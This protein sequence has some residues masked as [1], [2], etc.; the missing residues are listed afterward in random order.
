M[1]HAFVIACA[2]SLNMEID[3]S[4][5]VMFEDAWGPYKTEENCEIRASQMVD[6]SI[7]GNMT[8]IIF[9]MLNYPQMIYAEGHCKPPEG[10]QA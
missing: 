7:N 6:E 5:C 4:K 1:F 2:A 10:E 8:P 9:M 3:E